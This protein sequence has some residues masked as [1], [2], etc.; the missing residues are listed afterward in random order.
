MTKDGEREEDECKP[1]DWDYAATLANEG[2]TRTLAIFEA[3]AG[4]LYL[5]ITLTRLVPLSI[6]CPD[7]PRNPD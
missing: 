4:Q 3:L 7:V 5:V 2:M 1:L 6:V